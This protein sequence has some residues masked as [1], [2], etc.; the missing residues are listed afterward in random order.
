MIKKFRGKYDKICNTG[1]TADR[2]V[3]TLMPIRRRKEKKTRKK[4]KIK[5]KVS[6]KKKR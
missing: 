4:Q 5:S 3:Q 1:N 2:R 6:E